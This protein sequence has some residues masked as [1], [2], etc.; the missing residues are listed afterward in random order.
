[1][2]SRLEAQITSKL[3]SRKGDHKYKN[4]LDFPF[5]MEL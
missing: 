3:I 4:A 2:S 5:I 1:M